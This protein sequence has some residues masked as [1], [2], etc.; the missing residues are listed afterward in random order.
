MKRFIILLAV[1]VTCCLTSCAQA[2]NTTVERSNFALYETTNMWTFLKLDTRTGKIWQVQYS[3]EG[4]EYRFET[5][6]NTVDL[7]DGTNLKP[8]RFELYKTQNI[9]NFIL[10]DKYD[11]RTWQV[12]WGKAESRQMLRIFNYD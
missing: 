5:A 4:S 11:G 3:V 2:Q 10:L 6:L 12:Q 7:T 9:H 1:I 8:G